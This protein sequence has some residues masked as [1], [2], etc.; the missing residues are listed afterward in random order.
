MFRTFW[1]N[2]KDK[3]V[4]IYCETKTRQFLHGCIDLESRTIFDDFII[5][6]Y[7]ECKMY[8]HPRPAVN[9]VG[10]GATEQH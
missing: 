6:S 10:N 5:N 1:D 4:G 7:A 3:W 9:P 2:L 8:V